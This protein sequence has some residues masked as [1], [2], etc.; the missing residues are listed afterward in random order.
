VNSTLIDAC[1]G[2]EVEHTPVW[3]MRQ[4]G[5]YLPSYRKIRKDHT[6][7]E[8]AKNP[9]LSSSVSADSAKSLGTDAAILF[10]DIMI[11]LE[12]IGI[13]FKIQEDIGPIVENPVR[14]IREVELLGNFDARAHVPFVLEGIEKT[15]EKLDDSIPVIGFSGGPFTLASY[16]IE[17][18]PTREFTLTK[19][20][21]YEQPGAWG[22]L[23][24]RL[25]RLV[26]EYLKAQVRHGAGAVQLFDSWVGCLS[27]TDYERFVMPHT[28]E[29]FE[30]LS[31]G[32]PRIHFCADSA[33]LLAQLRMTGCDVLSVDWRIPIDEVWRVAGEKSAAQGNLDPVLAVTGGEPMEGQVEEILRRA[34][35]HRGHIFNLGH[36]VLKETPPQNLRRIVEI[37][38]KATRGNRA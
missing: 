19:R 21:M 16:I 2:K 20:F 36:G 24:G 38:H 35:G 22:A 3:F 7:L 25:S 15:L 11:P 37:V 26:T 28:T 34:R 32:V 5:R 17:G 6:V 31:T 10:A 33:S 27:P 30:A 9:E 18:A 4:A 13:K 23:M 12:G 29:I 8:I 14:S 1:R